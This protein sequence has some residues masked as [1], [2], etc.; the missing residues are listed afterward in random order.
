MRTIL[1]PAS[2]L[3]SQMG[4]SLPRPPKMNEEHSLP[5]SSNTTYGLYDMEEDHKDSD[6]EEE[7]EVSHKDTTD[8][9]CHL[10]HEDKSNNYMNP[11][12]TFN[13]QDTTLKEDKSS[14]YFLNDSSLD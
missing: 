6:D 11:A 5:S 7:S 10:T 2:N 13:S 4:L 9:Q 1:G 12:M 14:N 3:L 8:D